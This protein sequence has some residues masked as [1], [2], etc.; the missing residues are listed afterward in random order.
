MCIRD[1]LW[2]VCSC[3]HPAPSPTLIQTVSTHLMLPQSQE[4]LRRASGL[5]NHYYR[6]IL[7]SLSA[8]EAPIKST[9]HASDFIS[10]ELSWWWNKSTICNSA[11]GISVQL[12]TSTIPYLGTYVAAATMS[13]WSQLS[14][15]NDLDSWLNT[16]P[17]RQ[18]ESQQLGGAAGVNCS[19]YY[20]WQ[21]QV[22]NEHYSV[23]N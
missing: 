13:A 23:F 16:E 5:G 8:H 17:P 11:T 15:S 7:M 2:S 14:N 6:V 10:S 20:M 18:A 9:H 4:I 1:R 21:S 19:N 12:Y 3:R 22:E